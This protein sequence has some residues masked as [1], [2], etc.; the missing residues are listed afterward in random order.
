[1]SKKLLS[2]YVAVAVAVA[3]VSWTAGSIRP[4]ASSFAGA[5]APGTVEV[6]EQMLTIGPLPVEQY[7]AI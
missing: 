1:M 4:A 2:S 3:A 7:D 6:F 5:D